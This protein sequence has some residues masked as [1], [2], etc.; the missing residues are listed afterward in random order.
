MRGKVKEG[1]SETLRAV[2]ATSHLPPAT[3]TQE[4][5]PSP[6]TSA[7][8]SWAREHDGPPEGSGSSPPPALCPEG[9]PELRRFSPSKVGL[10]IGP[11]SQGTGGHL[12]SC[13]C[14][15]SMWR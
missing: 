4:P 14:K 3:H 11:G 9:F 6:K 12:P 7:L 10:L 1:K 8:T 2:P 5:T 13:F 15:S